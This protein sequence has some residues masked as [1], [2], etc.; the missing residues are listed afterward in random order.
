MVLPTCMP[1]LRRVLC[2]LCIVAECPQWLMVAVYRAC[3]NTPY[4]IWKKWGYQTIANVLLIAQGSSE[5]QRSIFLAYARS[6][7]RD[8]GSSYYEHARD[9][10]AILQA[11]SLCTGKTLASL[12]PYRGMHICGSM[13]RVMW[14]WPQYA[15][16]RPVIDAFGEHFRT[17]IS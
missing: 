10:D 4:F 2:R 17:I 15:A 1:V 9:F 8:V 13:A 3:K 5:P 14:R 16:C 6:W 12:P 11:D 7:L